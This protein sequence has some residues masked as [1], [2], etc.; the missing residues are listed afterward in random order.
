MPLSKNNLFDA[1]RE[2]HAIL[3]KGFHELSQALRAGNLSAAAAAA[4]ALDQT[5]GAHIAFEEEH[6]YPALGVL[7]G[8]PE[9]RRMAR[10]HLAGLEV[11][12]ALAHDHANDTIDDEERDH[13]LRQSQAMETHVAECGELF[14]A[15]GRIPPE[16]QAALYRSL[17]EWRAKRPRWTDYADSRNG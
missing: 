11:I 16:E 12:R 8:A 2:D 3:G 7:L 13:L 9:A 17:L 6:F 10:E 14:E 1:F 5:A 4:S 15:M